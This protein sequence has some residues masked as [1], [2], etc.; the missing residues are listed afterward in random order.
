MRFASAK[1]AMRAE[2]DTHMKVALKERPLMRPLEEVEKKVV[3]GE[4]ETYLNLLHIDLRLKKQRALREPRYYLLHSQWMH[5]V[6]VIVEAIASFWQK[7]IAS[8][9]LERTIVSPVA[10]DLKT[11]TAKRYVQV[12]EHFDDSLAV[13]DNT[14]ELN[15]IQ[16]VADCGKFLKEFMESMDYL[17]ES[18]LDLW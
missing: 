1:S 5:D 13:A 9:S 12:V 14:S 2:F 7:K 16:V 11:A 4:Q 15:A 3:Y 8:G 10:V 6:Q 17:S 18:D